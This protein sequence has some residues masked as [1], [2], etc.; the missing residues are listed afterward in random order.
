[1]ANFSL[2]THLFWKNQL[3]KLDSSGVAISDSFRD[4]DKIC[5]NAELSMSIIFIKTHSNYKVK[6]SLNV[7]E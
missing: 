4:T 3:L 6:L 1:M 2:V 7:P 5:P